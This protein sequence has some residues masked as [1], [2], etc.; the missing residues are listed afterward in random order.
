MCQRTR[1]II[2]ISDIDNITF[3]WDMD[4]HFSDYTKAGYSTPV[5]TSTFTE[6]KNLLNTK[7][8]KLLEGHDIGKEQFKD[9]LE[10]KGFNVKADNSDN[11]RKARYQYWLRYGYEGG[12]FSVELNGQEVKEFFYLLE[13]YAVQY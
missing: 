11:R 5:P 1:I 4:P 2:D 13:S 3:I 8:V 10:E 6:R 12:G 7:V 9:I